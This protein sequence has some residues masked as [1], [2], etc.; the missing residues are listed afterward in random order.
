M[1]IFMLL[2]NTARIMLCTLNLHKV[3]KDTGC[4]F[5][6]KGGSSPDRKSRLVK[7]HPDDGRKS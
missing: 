2:D 4:M 6:S 1:E 3:V 7:K 5:K